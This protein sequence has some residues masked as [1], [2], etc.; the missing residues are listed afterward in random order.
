MRASQAHFLAAAGAMAMLAACSPSAP[1]GNATTASAS[2]APMG[3]PCDRGLVTKA[4]TP[5]PCWAS[6][7]P[8]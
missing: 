6:R 2:A 1:V 8:R 5:P 3:T 4:V 7:P